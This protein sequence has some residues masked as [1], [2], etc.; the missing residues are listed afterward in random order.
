MAPSV[1]ADPG[2]DGQLHGCSMSPQPDCMNSPGTLDS[3]TCSLCTSPPLHGVSARPPTSVWKHSSPFTVNAYALYS[4]KLLCSVGAC[5]LIPGLL[6]ILL[7]VQDSCYERWTVKELLMLCSLSLPEGELLESR[8]DL[9]SPEAY[10]RP[11][12]RVTSQ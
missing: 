7:L 12:H 5:L 11:M 3:L 4:V 8:K 10:L 9:R 6:P 1:P 2:L